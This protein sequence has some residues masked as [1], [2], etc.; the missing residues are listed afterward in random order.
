[1]EERRVQ[2]AVSGA[3][4]TYYCDLDTQSPNK[5]FRAL[6]DDARVYARMRPEEKGNLIK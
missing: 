5:F 4:F 3:A 1:M 6:L 2:Y